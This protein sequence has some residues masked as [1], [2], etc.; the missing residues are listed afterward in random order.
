MC[1]PNSDLIGRR[2]VAEFVGPLLHFVEAGPVGIH[3]SNRACRTSGCAGRVA[4]AQIAL[5]NF[6]CLLHVIDRAKWAC[7]G[8]HLTT[9]ASGF[10]HHHGA[11]DFVFGDRL[12]GASVQTPSF[13][14]LRAG[15]RHFFAGLMEV[16]HFDAGFGCGECAVVLERTGHLA[17]QTARA[18]VWVDVQ[19]FLHLGLQLAMNL[20]A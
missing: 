11:S 4:T 7:N 8:A 19:D 14:A 12:H 2:L 15:V 16:K 9:D 10:V 18:F 20:V 6:A 5:L 3:E 1:A 13:I 17:L